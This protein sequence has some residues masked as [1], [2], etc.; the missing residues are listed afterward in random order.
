M[1]K[2]TVSIE[3]VIVKEVQL[4]KE[5]STL[6]RRPFNDIVL[7]NLA[8]SGEHAA[9]TL[10]NG[11]VWI[12]DL[13][14]TNG[15]FLDGQRIKHEQFTEGSVVQIGKCQIQLHGSVQSQAPHPQ[16][17]APAAPRGPRVQV[18]NG[19]AAGRA[20]ELTKVVTRIGKPGISVASITRRPDGLYLAMIEG[21]HKPAINGA[22]LEDAPVQLQNHDQ[23]D[24]GGV[25]LEFLDD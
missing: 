20:M 1:P 19:P 12:E 21:E 5:R 8:V 24:L 6:G 9:I 25:R 11:D 14:S 16:A 7:D 13:G 23:I 4:A 2:L 18:L 10:Q 3:G 17:S 15:T 22:P